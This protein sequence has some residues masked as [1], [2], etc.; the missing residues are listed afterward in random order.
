VDSHFKTDDFF[1]IQFDDVK[2]ACNSSSTCFQRAENSYIPR[3]VR[4][5]LQN[6]RSQLER[7][8]AISWL[9]ELKKYLTE[10]LI[11][12]MCSR[13]SVKMQQASSSTAK[14]P[15]NNTLLAFLL[16]RLEFIALWHCGRSDGETCISYWMGTSAKRNSK[17][18]PASTKTWRRWGIKLGLYRLL[19]THFDFDLKCMSETFYQATSEK[20]NI[21][22]EFAMDEMLYSCYCQGNVTQ[23]IP[24]KP[25]PC[26]LKI[27]VV[28][29]FTAKTKLP[30]CVM[31]F[32]DVNPERRLTVMQCWGK[33]FEVARKTQNQTFEVTADSW[34]F[35]PDLMEK[36]PSNV[37]V[38]V[39]IGSRK[40]T[41]AAKF[42]KED[43][44]V[45]SENT[46]TLM[47]PRWGSFDRDVVIQS[48][49]SKAVQCVMSNVFARRETNGMSSDDAHAAQSSTTSSTASSSSMANADVQVDAR[50]RCLR[51]I[52]TAAQKKLR[53]LSLT[54][55]KHVIPLL[56]N[57]FDTSSFE[58]KSKK[59]MW[60]TVFLTQ[61]NTTNPTV[62]PI[63]T[64][65]TQDSIFY[66][67]LQ[68]AS[69]LAKKPTPKKGE[70]MSTL[71]TRGVTAKKTDT[72][73]ILYMKKLLSEEN[74]EV[75]KQCVQIRAEKLGNHVCT[76]FNENG[77]FVCKRYG[78]RFNSVDVSNKY[79]YSAYYNNKTRNYRTR[80]MD[81]YLFSIVTNLWIWW[82][83]VTWVE[84]RSTTTQHGELD[85]LSFFDRL[86]ELIKK[87][88]MQ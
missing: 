22:A 30:L 74:P 32:A 13:T 25:H 21:G 80:L 15:D 88:F 20:F 9:P 14:A 50:E 68:S 18:V 35:V 47:L 53:S 36:L 42:V 3:Q 72:K 37:Y 78:R 64:V 38:T 41:K 55:S 54:D 19:N 8:S 83:E 23:Y 67:L 16:S 79:I 62:R 17:H 69:A 24:R 71:R 65:W 26:G 77:A 48:F 66:T 40:F 61:T 49:G 46:R 85:L 44:A 87:E 84:N 39:S 63:E 27:F 58:S 73:T 12:S 2:E 59:E 52:S 11:G 57:N 82:C 33:V 76:N 28:A 43:I 81:E 6:S 4:N 34:F 31:W 75:L 60:D 5:T 70:L 10:Q 45:D 56:T 1:P 86:I 7:M 51:S 29:C